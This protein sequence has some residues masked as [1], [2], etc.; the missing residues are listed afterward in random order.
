[1]RRHQPHQPCIDELLESAKRALGSAETTEWERKFILSLLGAAKR[2]GP[3]WLPSSKQ[4][5][6]LRRIVEEHR[7]MKLIEEEPRYRAAGG[8]LL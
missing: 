4:E 7:A 5:R 2:G 3:S 1:M 6:V 8:A